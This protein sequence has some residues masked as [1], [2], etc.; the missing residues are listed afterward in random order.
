MSHRLFHILAISFLSIPLFSQQD[1]SR[2]YEDTNGN[3]YIG[4]Y[5]PDCPCDSSAFQAICPSEC[6]FIPPDSFIWELKPRWV[7]RV[8]DFSNI[9]FYYDPKPVSGDIDNDGKVEVLLYA[10]DIPSKI[11]ILDGETGAMKYSF[12]VEFGWQTHIAIA[13]LTGDGFAEILVPGDRSQLPPRII[14]CY[15]YTG[16]LLW[17]S[18][19]LTPYM[20]NTRSVIT[21]VGV[22][23]FNGDG[24]PEV[25]MG[26]VILNG[27]TG[28]IIAYG[29]EGLGCSAYNNDRFC[30]NA[31][32]V[33]S[34]L[35][36][37]PGLELAAGN[38][39][40]TVSLNNL[41]DTLGNEMIPQFAPA[42]V[43]DGLTSVADIDGDGLLDVVVHRRMPDGTDDGLW[44]WNPRTQSL[45]S[46]TFSKRFSGGIPIIADLTGNCVPEISTIYNNELRINQFIGTNQL[47]TTQALSI[48]EVSGWTT[49]VAFDFNGNG[50]MEIVHRDEFRLRI[51]D[52][53]SG[54]MLC[55]YPVRS[56]T[57]Y[58]G[59]IIA[60]VTGDGRANI[61]VTDVSGHVYCFESGGSPWAPARKVWNQPGYHIT[62]IND[63][64]SVPRQQQNHAAFFPNTE[65]CPQPTCPQL[66]NSFRAQASYRT[67]NGCTQWPAA[68][69]TIQAQLDPCS[70]NELLL[71]LFIDNIGNRS[72][73][74]CISICVYDTDP[75]TGGADSIFCFQHCFVLD[76][77]S[78]DYRHQD[79]IALVIPIAL[80]SSQPDTLYFSINDVG[81][82]PGIHNFQQT[83]IVE[84]NYLNNFAS[85]AIE[86]HFTTLHLGPDVFL[87]SPEENVLA[88]NEVFVSYQ[89]STG[90]S[91]N[92]I[93]VTEPGIYSLSVTDDCGRVLIDSVE[94]RIDAPEIDSPLSDVALCPDELHTI[95][96]TG[97]YDSLSWTP[98]QWVSCSDCSSISITEDAEGIVHLV[99][100]RA[101]C[102]LE[103][104]LRISRIIPIE[105]DREADICPGT[106]IEIDGESITEPGRYEQ[107]IQGCDSLIIWNVA[108]LPADS[109]SIESGICEGDS[110]LIGSQ[111]YSSPGSYSQLLQNQ[112]GCDSTVHISITSSE[113]Y[114]HHIALQLC[115][116]QVIIIEELTIDQPGEYQLLRSSDS[117]CDSLII[118]QVEGMALPTLSYERR[119][120]SGETLEL[121]GLSFDQ[122]GTYSFTLPA[123]SGCDTIVTLDME[124]YP[125]YESIENLR[126]CTGDTLYAAGESFTEDTEFSLILTTFHGCDSLVRYEL[127]FDPMPIQAVELS[128]CEGDTLLYNE[129]I[130]TQATFF[131]DTL[132][133]DNC[134]V[135]QD[136]TVRELLADYTEEFI[137]LCP[138]DSIYIFDAV[139]TTSGIYT[140][141]YTRAEACDSIH[142]TEVFALLTPDV[143]AQ[144]DCEDI[145]IDVRISSPHE[146][147]QVLWDNGSTAPQTRYFGQATATLFLSAENDCERLIELILPTLPD[148]ENLPSLRD[149]II[150]ENTGLIIDLGLDEG[151][152]IVQWSPPEG[153]SCDHCMRVEILSLDNQTFEIIFIHESGCV[154]TGRFSVGIRKTEDIRVPNIIAPDRGGENSFWTVFTTG[155]ISLLD[156]YIFDRWGNMVHH[157]KPGDPIRWDGTF[158]GQRVENGVYVY[159]INYLTGAEERKVLTGDVT[160]VR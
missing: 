58:E 33:A 61:I 160:V 134:L 124:L 35:L 55:S 66:Y 28:N 141:T 12:P 129:R 150:D 152:W 139:V 114:E 109:Y 46:K 125:A 117:G 76:S 52:G 1:C 75:L 111:W 147:W 126:S 90:S 7:S 9:A 105:V 79:L 73:D 142:T 96:I 84:C 159:L 32:S 41:N 24:I 39:V 17:Q 4:M 157:I 98:A 97:V 121:H 68:D 54:E 103:D 154:Y 74:S 15:R 70:D 43:L 87:C 93:T 148:I 81:D 102:T 26:N 82:L 122:A 143:E 30:A 135:R 85:I 10:R 48:T 72:I 155:D 110:V 119:I 106:S 108:L 149:T 16:E 50:K 107:Y 92:Q 133:I 23:D 101:G 8:T 78:G 137:Y 86:S 151:A 67:R 140:H 49:L 14:Y 18:E 65:E 20:K 120:C 115:E 91:Q 100:H 19:D 36:E 11:A 21:T 83:G 44:V 158:R 130:I 153:V 22:A 89:W 51:F 63:D 37:H 118:Y 127:I 69:F 112:Y 104:S 57:N 123:V 2:L 99:L 47:I 29:K 80:L 38:V 59:P 138:G 71:S 131:I 27:L 88:P 40:Y 34:D 31:L 64:L 5:D 128:L 45:I 42:E 116:G 113:V 25:Y 56:E 60:D 156:I 145:A 62:N 6:N 95:E 132:R 77:L 146:G 94:I 53:D 3:G 136:V 144:V 13:D